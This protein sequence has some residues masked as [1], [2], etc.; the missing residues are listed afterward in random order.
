LYVGISKDSFERYLAHRQSS[1]WTNDV[2]RIEIEQLRGFVLIHAPVCRCFKI[3]G[4]RNQSREN[5]LSEMYNDHSQQI[6]HT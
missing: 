6:A 3:F 5:I 1:H 4:I 2:V